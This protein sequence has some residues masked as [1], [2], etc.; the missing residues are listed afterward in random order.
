MRVTDEETKEVVW[1]GCWL[2]RVQQD[3]AI[4]DQPE[5]KPWV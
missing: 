2:V 4:D 5:A 1:S 3:I